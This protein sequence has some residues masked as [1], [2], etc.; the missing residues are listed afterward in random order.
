[1]RAFRLLNF[2]NLSRG[3]KVRDYLSWGPNFGPKILIIFG[4]FDNVTLIFEDG[5][6]QKFRYFD[7]KCPTSMA[8]N[9]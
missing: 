9:F 7:K 5:L 6:D 3:S 4:Q 1:M 2:E 8:Y